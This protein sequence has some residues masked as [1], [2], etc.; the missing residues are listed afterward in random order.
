MTVLLIVALASPLACKSPARFQVVGIDVVPPEVVAGEA[1]TISAQVENIGGTEGT[2]TVTL[3][4][5]RAEIQSKVIKLASKMIETVSFTLTKDKPGSYNVEINDL[6]ATFRVLKPAEFTFS[7]LLIT[8]PIAEVS[9]EITITADVSNT[10]EVEGRYPVTLIIN[11]D[12]VETKELTVSAGATAKVGFAFAKDATGIYSIEVGSL[13]GLVIVSETGNIIA[14]L[15]VAYPELYQELLKLPELK[16]TSVSEDTAIEQITHLALFSKNSEVKEALQLIIKGGTPNPSDYK[17]AV[18][19]YNTE[20]QVL[21][22]LAERNEFRQDDTLPLAIAMTHGVWVALGDDEVRKTVRQDVND[23]LNYFLETNEK[24]KAAGYYQLEDY[25]LEAKVYLCWRANDL[26]RGGHIH[27]QL[28]NGGDRSSSPI[29]IHIFYENE[30]RPISL[31]DYCWN[32]VSVNTLVKMREY[33]EKS[34]WLNNNVDVLVS[35]VENYFTRNWNF[36][37]PKDDWFDYEGERTVNHNMNNANLEF[38]YLS[39][40]GVGI[41]VCDDEMSLVDAFLKSWGISSGAMVRTYGTKDGSNHTHIF[42]YEPKSKTWR[43]YAQQLNVGATS[44]NWNIYIFTP[45]VIQHNYYKY[46]QDTQ[47]WYMKMLNL[48]YKIIGT[49]GSQIK[50]TFTKGIPTSEIKQWVFPTL[51]ND[52][53]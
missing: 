42:Y 27:Y 37:E 51:S 43:C 23:L 39:K 16:E 9:K 20:L 7:N 25:P 45:P 26:G 38:D 12:K 6:S 17:Y 46:Y 14:Q 13:S 24:Q 32:N 15:E 3:S 11:G 5:D 52:T 1:A 33:M 4:V 53:R 44:S 36:T 2:Y 34:G 10:G 8:P 35:N 47:Q 29:N 49:L 28:I 40:T 48:Y 41:G 30:K 19:N 31:K 18:P 50:E 22:W 21:Y